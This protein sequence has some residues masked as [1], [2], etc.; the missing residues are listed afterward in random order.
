MSRQRPKPDGGRK[1]REER[2]VKTIARIEL[3]TDAVIDKHMPYLSSASLTPFEHTTA[4]RAAIDALDRKFQV[5]SDYRVARRHLAKKVLAYNKARKANLAV[6]PALMRSSPL[7]V[8]RT[9]SWCE[10]RR[11]LNAAHERLMHALGAPIQPKLSAEERLGLALYF[12]VTYGALGDYRA[13][14]SL[15]QELAAFPKIQIH[16]GMQIAY[17]WLCYK[18]KGAC[19]AVVDDELVVYRPWIITTPCRPSLLGF[20]KSQ[21]MLD[22]RSSA[23]SHFDLIRTGFQAAS[24]EA[25]PVKSFRRFCGV[26]SAIYERQEGVNMPEILVQIANGQIECVSPPPGQWESLFTEY[27][28]SEARLD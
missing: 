8:R 28:R 11:R 3:E 23:L 10:R 19:N 16:R 17:I 20:L 7:R 13:V 4:A 24:G 2:R 9:Q 12:A 21:P 25:L 14:S 22:P 18:S 6:P 5:P 15:R 1:A 27:A 26:G